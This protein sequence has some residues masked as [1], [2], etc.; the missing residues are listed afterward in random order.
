VAFLGAL[1][2][3]GRP[4]VRSLAVLIRPER[5]AEVVYLRRFGPLDQTVEQ[6]ATEVR[7][8]GAPVDGTDAVFTPNWLVVS[9]RSRFAA[10]HLTDVRQVFL[11]T[12]WVHFHFVIPLWRRRT[13]V[14]RSPGAPDAESRVTKAGADALLAYAAR[15][16]SIA[17]G[18]DAVA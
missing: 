16:P 13:V 5:S 3:V 1:Y 18:P 9:G 11:R 14:F 6:L 12:A 8:A 2:A 15:F 7:F 4:Y 10:R 17:R